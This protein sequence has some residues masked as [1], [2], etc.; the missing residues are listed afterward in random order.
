MP[1]LGRIGACDQVD[2]MLDLRAQGAAAQRPRGAPG[3]HARNG[4][5]SPALL[6]PARSKYTHRSSSKDCRAR[7]PIIITGIDMVLREVLDVEDCY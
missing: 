7:E 3:G 5:E 1:L 2:G 6:Q 4:R